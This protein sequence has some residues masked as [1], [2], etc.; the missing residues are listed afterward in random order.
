MMGLSVEEI[1]GALGISAAHCSARLQG[2]R[3]RL[4]ACLEQTWFASDHSP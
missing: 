4:R 1:C 3:M 2:A